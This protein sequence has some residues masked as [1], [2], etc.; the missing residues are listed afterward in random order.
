VLGYESLKNLMAL[1]LP[2]MYFCVVLLGQPISVRR[3]VRHSRLLVLRHRRCIRE[4]LF[5]RYSRPFALLSSS[6]AASTQND[7]LSPLTQLDFLDLPAP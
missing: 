6:Q 3:T 1:V 4:I 7:A 2:A 5:S